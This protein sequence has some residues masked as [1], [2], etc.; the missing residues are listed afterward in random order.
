MGDGART[1]TK[2]GVKYPAEQGSYHVESSRVKSS[3]V[4]PPQ[5]N[6]RIVCTA[7]YGTSTVLM[8]ASTQGIADHSPTWLDW[9]ILWLHHTA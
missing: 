9:R 3:R 4:K 5:L 7:Q 2:C 8:S 6:Y 1:A